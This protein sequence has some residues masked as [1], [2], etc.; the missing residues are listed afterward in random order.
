MK[1]FTALL[2][3]L[4]LVCGIFASCGND[5]SSSSGENI[6]NSSSSQT[7][8]A[9]DGSDTSTSSQPANTGDEDDELTSSQPASSKPASS[10]PASSQ[11]ASSKPASSQPASSK[12]ASS[13][14]SSSASSSTG[15]GTDTA[16]TYKSNK[17]KYDSLDLYFTYDAAAKT[18]EFKQM[19]YISQD[20][21][22]QLG[23]TGTLAIM[24]SVSYQVTETADGDNKILKGTPVLVKAGLEGTAAE[25]YI[26]LA[27]QAGVEAEL[28]ALL[29]GQSITDKTEIEEMTY[30]ID[31]VMT[32]KAS[33][34]G[35]KL[36]VVEILEEYTEYGSQNKCKDIYKITN[37]V[38]RSEEWIVNGESEG[39]I[40]YDENG[41]VISD[42]PSVEDNS[43]IMIQ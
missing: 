34:S 21:L 3:V 1:R 18:L 42:E 38:V 8:S 22:N 13:T 31:E 19:S 26:K 32:V 12:P 16:V 14:E 9:G 24:Q 37:D 30:M 20:D 6:D 23:L 43:D 2:L 27:E 29:K 17:I 36:T 5:A 7:S 33:L 41:E 25:E 4:L 39:V 11:P 35:T 15:E 28:L 40:E 10:K